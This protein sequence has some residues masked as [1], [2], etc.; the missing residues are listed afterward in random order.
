[1]SNTLTRP[2]SLVAAIALVLIGQA[3]GAAD[4]MPPT[5]AAAEAADVEALGPWQIRLRALGVIT[6]DSGTVN[7]IDGADLSYSD[8][9]V[10]ELDISYYFTDNIAAELIL[11]TTYA[12]V[13]A[14]GSIDALGEVGK[15]WLLPPR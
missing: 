6:R 2:L 12:N 5:A 13:D 15:T 14:A 9:V 8:T 1:M 3:A 11:G 4:L 7:G 10:P